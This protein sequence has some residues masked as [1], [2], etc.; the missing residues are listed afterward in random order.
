MQYTYCHHCGKR[1][2]AGAM[3][4]ISCGK[5]LKTAEEQLESIERVKNKEKKINVW[6]IVKIVLFVI[7]VVVVYNKYSDQIL[8][9][10]RQVIGR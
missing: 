5:I 3:K 2:V 8:S 6:P 1:L 9:L 7:L 10:L 4:C